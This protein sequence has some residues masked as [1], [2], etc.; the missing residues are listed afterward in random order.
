MLRYMLMV[1]LAVVAAVSGYALAVHPAHQPALALDTDWLNACTDAPAPGNQ[2]VPTSSSSGQATWDYPDECPGCED[3]QGDPSPHYTDVELDDLTSIS[4]PDQGTTYASSVYV[5]F[6]QSMSNT[7]E[8]I[9]TVQWRTGG[10]ALIATTDMDLF[11]GDPTT[12]IAYSV[13]P[14]NL[15]KARPYKL[16]VYWGGDYGTTNPA[17]GNALEGFTVYIQCCTAR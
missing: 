4:C 9:G 6:C 14:C 10:G 16:H 11:G 5:Y 2:Y 3:T 7:G 1:S 17:I 12:N 15:N 13:I 8:K